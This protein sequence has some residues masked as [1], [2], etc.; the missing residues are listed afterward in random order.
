MKHT[1]YLLF[2]I[3]LTVLSFSGFM[4]PGDSIGA[5]SKEQVEQ[6]RTDIRKMAD[7]TLKRLYEMQPSA[8]KAVKKAA[9]YAAFSNFGMKIL[10]FG[11]GSGKGLAINNATGKSV[12]MQMIEVQAGLGIGIK[13]FRLV[14]IFENQSDF[15]DFIT[16]GW[17]FGGQATVAA[18]AS[19][20]GAALAGAISIKPGVW[21]Y[22]LTD[23]GLAAELTAKGTKYFKDQNLN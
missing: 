7:S 19:G 10:F 12:Y 2:G 6:Q 11:G 15:D 1:T 22:Q 21:L 18:Q 8:Q 17:E 5:P 20:E 23:D 13:K 14:W 9:G 16:S 4:V 3:T